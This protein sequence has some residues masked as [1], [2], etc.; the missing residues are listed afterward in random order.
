MPVHPGFLPRQSLQEGSIGH[1]QGGGN[2]NLTAAVYADAYFFLSPPSDEVEG[3][4]REQ[5]FHGCYYKS[6]QDLEPGFRE[7]KR[8]TALVGDEA[9][10]PVTIGSEIFIKIFNEIS[11][12]FLILDSHKS[13]LFFNDVLP[14]LLGWDTS[15]ILMRQEELLDYLGR[16]L[17][18][19][20]ERLIPDRT[21]NLYSFE[22]SVFC[23]P[24]ASGASYKL[25]KLKKSNEMGLSSSLLKELPRLLASLSD[26][27]V[28]VAPN[29]HVLQANSAFFRSFDLKEGHSPL[30]QIRDFY[31]YPEDLEEKLTFLKDQGYV[32]GRE[33]LLLA[34]SGRSRTFEDTSWVLKNNQGQ[35]SGYISLMK[36]LTQMKNLESRLLLAERNRHQLFDSLLVS[37]ILVDPTGR[38][39]NINAAARK[40]Y[41]YS[42]EE[43]SGEMFD[44]LF[45]TTSGEEGGFASVKTLADRDK[46]ELRTVTRVKKDGS[47]V[48]TQLSSRIVKDVTEEVVAYTV[49][50]QDITDRVALEDELK[51]S[52]EEIKK[53]QS[54]TI[55]GFA[56]L[57][58]FRDGDT[59]SHLERIREYTRVLGTFLQESSPYEDYINNEYLE[60]LTLSSAL[61]DVGKVG[62]E[63]RVLLKQGLLEEDEFAAMKQHAFLG[64]EALARVDEALETRSFLTMGK[65]IAFYHHERWD[66]TGYPEGRREEEI[67][68]SARI[69][70]L[71][72]VYDALTSKRPYKDAWSHEEAVE[73][74]KRARGKQFDPHIVD[75]FLAHHT[76]FKN[77]KHFI[78]LESQAQDI[79]CLM[80][81]PEGRRKSIR[82]EFT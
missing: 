39:L 74:I 62:I 49:M 22:V 33:V 11:E 63:D 4:G 8:R 50:E 68:L 7:L 5:L 31:V 70:A 61:H 24:T 29:G 17:E 42:W 54:A 67:P 71:A 23:L 30:L 35:Y 56:R 15:E 80:E 58:E 21:G 41:G 6:T 52:L 47:L 76:V 34:P 48:S 69:V 57:T 9:R 2:D 1:E 40:L 73:E 82:K 65:E 13:I 44:D 36:D 45:K 79:S 37:I 64:G 60:T 26:A 53:T 3:K 16:D 27:V 14:P 55:L 59:G 51:N 18:R 28:M 75:V 10:R 77:I 19:E 38:V 72:D 32:S 12:G 81:K 66:G 43:V 25:I 46:G 20:V 78:E